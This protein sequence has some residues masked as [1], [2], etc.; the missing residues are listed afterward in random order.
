MVPIDRRLTHRRGGASTS[1]VAL[2]AALTDE[3]RESRDRRQ[4]PR[5]R[6]DM[7]TIAHFARGIDA[8]ES[9][10]EVIVDGGDGIRMVAMFT[11]GCLAIEPIGEGRPSLHIEACPR[12]VEPVVVHE[13]RSRT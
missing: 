12:H 2:G 4:M 13:R 8:G 5:R 9:R 6:A 3:R 7:R 11:C 10:L 1:T